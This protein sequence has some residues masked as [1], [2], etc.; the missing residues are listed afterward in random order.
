MRISGQDWNVPP[1]AVQSFVTPE[2]NGRVLLPKY[3]QTRLVKSVEKTRKVKRKPRQ[4]T[5]SKTLTAKS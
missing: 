1:K 5:E 3:H 4:T 2:T